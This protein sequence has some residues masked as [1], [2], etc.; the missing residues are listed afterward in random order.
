MRRV[1]QGGI[2]KEIFRGGKWEEDEERTEGEVD[3]PE[4]IGGLILKD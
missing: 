3:F 1:G 2:R 4:M